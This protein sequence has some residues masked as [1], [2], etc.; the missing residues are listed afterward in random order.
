MKKT[1]S[2]MSK[3]LV[4]LMLTEN[5]LQALH[6]VCPII[7]RN[8]RTCDSKVAIWR[9]KLKPQIG[10]LV[11]LVAKTLY[12]V[13]LLR[14]SMLFSHSRPFERKE[15]LGEIP[16]SYTVGAKICFM[17]WIPSFFENTI[18]EY[19]CNWCVSDE[20]KRNDIEIVRSNSLDLGRNA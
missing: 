6:F 9:K 19:N 5:C 3:C 12:S 1:K 16:K 18:P 11:A 20:T 10:S 14:S 7:G 13:T 15:E 17:L 2:S 4:S 8:E